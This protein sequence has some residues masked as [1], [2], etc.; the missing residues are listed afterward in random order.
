MIVF[1]VGG[2]GS[3][4]TYALARQA[5]R[6]VR[7]RRYNVTANFTI[8]LPEN[9]NF[10][11]WNQPE[12]DAFKNLKCG[13]HLTDEA[14]IFFDSRKHKSLSD[15]ARRKAIEHRKD[16]CHMFMAVQTM[17]YVDA[18]FRG[19][20]G[21]VARVMT[22]VKVPFLGW[23]FPRSRILTKK[24][25]HGCDEVPLDVV[26]D[27]LG[28]RKWFGFGTIFI[29]RQYPAADLMEE[30]ADDQ[31]LRGGRAPGATPLLPQKVGWF[32]YDQVVGASYESHEKIS[33]KM[34][35]H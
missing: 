19:I 33:H 1:Y 13:F 17:R 7:L 14:G 12:D 21:T 24:C 2:V 28:W 16:D 10:T 23:F 32:M 35:G 3:G 20:A 26:P 11:E 22:S 9:I 18:V 4:K 25:Q 30:G 29:W 15:D 27:D 6:V 8:R 5:H 31:A 34:N